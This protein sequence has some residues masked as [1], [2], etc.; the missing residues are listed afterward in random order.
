MEII[1]L[2]ELARGGANVGITVP[3]IG[4]LELGF[5]GRVRRY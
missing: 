5:C 3:N 1:W 2:A 4:R